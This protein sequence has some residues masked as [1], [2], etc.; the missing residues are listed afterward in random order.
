MTEIA[1]CNPQSLFCADFPAILPLGQNRNMDEELKIR[2]FLLLLALGCLGI[3]LMPFA[4]FLWLNADWVPN[5][6]TSRL[7]GATP[8]E[9]RALL[10]DPDHTDCVKWAFTRRT[11]FAEFQ[12]YFAADGRVEDFYYDR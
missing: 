12:V 9:V 3:L 7:R 6:V 4:A 11:R 8:A 5:S 10:G 1:D 2:K